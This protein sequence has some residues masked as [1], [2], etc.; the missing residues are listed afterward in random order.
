MNFLEKRI[1]KDGVIKADGVLKVDSFLNHQ[2]DVNLLIELG[3]QVK[4]K[5]E[6]DG[7][8]KILTLEASGIAIAAAFTI[9]TEEPPCKCTN[10]AAAIAEA[11]PISA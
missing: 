6:K 11:E 7:V 10:A 3:K 1:I 9:C 5:F 8:T 2:I 4:E